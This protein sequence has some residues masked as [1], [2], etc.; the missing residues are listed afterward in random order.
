MLMREKDGKKL[1][2]KQTIG[3][4]LGKRGRISDKQMNEMRDD[5]F[6]DSNDSTE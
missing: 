3:I 2:T 5:Y 1:D 6:N 4:F